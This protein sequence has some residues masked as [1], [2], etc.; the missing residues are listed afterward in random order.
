MS[1]TAVALLA[2]LEAAI[3]ALVGLGVVL[4]PLMLLWG[5]HFGLTLDVSIFLRATAD[6]WLLGHGVDLVVQLDPLT[7]ELTGIAGAGE[8]F[9][10]TIA[11]LGFALVSALF[12]VRLGR[13]A[14]AGGHAV[15]GVLAATAVFAAIGAALGVAAA[16]PAATPSVW[17]AVVLPAFVMAL[18]ATIGSVSETLRAE[19]AGRADAS[20]GPLLAR[21]RALPEFVG[22]VTGAAVRI[23]A[24]T[25]FGVLAAAAVLVAILI[26]ADYATMI[27]LSQAIG[28]GVDGGLA[29][30][31]AELAVL[32]NAVIWAASWLLGPGFA[33]GAGS[34]VSPTGTL[35]GPV[36]GVPLLGVLPAEGASLGI[37]WLIVPLVLAFAGANLVWPRIARVRDARADLWW[38]PVAVAAASGVVAGV[39]MGL[40]A[41]WSGGALGPGRL[42][43]TGPDPWPVAAIAAATVFL[44]AV[45]GAFTA[46]AFPR[47]GGARER[48]ADEASAHEAHLA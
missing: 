18:G 28:A 22:A 36:P 7:A 25:V 41:W 34:T 39:V 45:A 38:A 16:A 8:P 2:A 17:Q 32:P 10:L 46:R 5:L 24:G 15:T 35:L 1:R 30:T 42:A 23:G 27:G 4:V 12:G 21:W 14:A 33:F 3:A 37:V 20:A 44:G 6:V 9:A 31:V 29:I 13:R 48:D 26:A 19:R 40:L 11:A 47:D 43:V